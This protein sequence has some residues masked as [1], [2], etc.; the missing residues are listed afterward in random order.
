MWYT[1]TEES[2]IAPNG[3]KVFQIEYKDGT[4]GGFIGTNVKL[5][6]N[7]CDID[8]NTL[9]YGA[10]VI[11]GKVTITNSQIISSMVSVV[12]GATIKQSVIK[13]SF[14][15]VHRLTVEDSNVDNLSAGV[16][17]NKDENDAVLKIRDH[18]LIDSVKTE[19]KTKIYFEGK[20]QILFKR[21]DVSGR[22]ICFKAYNSKISVSDSLVMFRKTSKTS[23]IND[24]LHLVECKD[25][26]MVVKQSKLFNFSEIKNKGKT[27]EISRSIVSGNFS[28]CGGKILR[29]TF[30]GKFV[31]NW[32]SNITNTKFFSDTIVS[33]EKCNPEKT[34]VNIDGSEFLNSCSLKYTGKGDSNVR[35]EITNLKAFGSATILFKDKLSVLSSIIRDNALIIDGGTIVLSTIRDNAVVCAKSIVGCIFSGTSVVGCDKK[36]RP[37]K[38]ADNIIIEKVSASSTY[39]IVC[40]DYCDGAL[41]LLPNNSV[42]FCSRLRNIFIRT[43]K[44]D[45]NCTISK[46]KNEVFARESHLFDDK[47]KALIS[48]I[49]KQIVPSDIPEDI[50][51]SLVYFAYWDM[52]NSLVEKKELFEEQRF[53]YNDLRVSFRVDIKTRKMVQFKSSNA[54]NCSTFKKF[55]DQINVV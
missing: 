13:E 36:N 10:T 26:D 27:L 33:A 32:V 19:G 4:K 39:D 40:M 1:L 5:P 6:K 18:S 51:S 9:I 37:I 45:F 16:V 42:R 23:E 41:V 53:L 15:D 2:K 38:H 17:G 31:V 49:T 47:C 29:S 20:S 35:V 46:L 50:V 28:T 3:E 55:I 21:A 8:E 7:K 11:E 48:E 14:F 52:A 12:R 25:A 22:D 34:I 44:D 54:S 24:I 43:I 30:S